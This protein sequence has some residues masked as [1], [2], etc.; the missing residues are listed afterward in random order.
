MITHVAASYP[1]IT[2]SDTDNCI[3]EGQ[4]V[5]LTCKVTYSGT[6]LMPLKMR[7]RRLSWLGTSQSFS[8]Q[9]SRTL[10]TVNASSVY[11]SSYTFIANRQS[12][13]YYDCGV[14]FS[15]LSGIVLS[16]VERQY[17]NRPYI[18]RPYASYNYYLS[19]L[20]PPNRVAS[21]RLAFMS[22]LL[23]WPHCLFANIFKML[24]SY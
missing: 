22:M 2:S 17:T 8:S 13:D 10:N 24:S 1:S 18:W 7:W 15:Y 12:N 11:R 9:S 16:G 6:N 3:L 20:F 14:T 21:K 5:R 4:I 23:I 19:S